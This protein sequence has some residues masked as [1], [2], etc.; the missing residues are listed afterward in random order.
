MVLVGGQALAF[1]MDRYD[2]SAGTAMITHDGDALGKVANAHDLAV[3]LKATLLKPPARA[4]TALVAQIRIPAPGGRFANIDILHVLYTVSGLRKS[5][6]FTAAVI[7][8]SI[9]FE[10]RPG[11]FIRVMDPLDLL[12]SRVQN[13]AGL[14][15]DKGPHVLTQVRWA[16][17]VVKAILLKLA[18]AGEP[19]EGRLGRKLQ[20]VL[21]LSESRAGRKLLVEHD[22]DVLDAVATTAIRQLAPQHDQQLDRIEEIV[23]RRRSA[24]TKRL[25]NQNPV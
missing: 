23:R 17:E 1:W 18:G 14:L 13:A 5:S 22:I 6:E 7:D 3:A 16:I 9:E 15:E 4:R 19:A 8:N 21:T 12:D 11:K 2:I 25:S 10:W 24:R 20:T